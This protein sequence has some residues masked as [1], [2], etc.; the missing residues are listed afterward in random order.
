MAPWLLALVL[1]VSM[2]PAGA[3]TGDQ[4][5]QAANVRYAAP[6]GWTVEDFPDHRGTFMYALRARDDVE[7]SI[8]IELSSTPEHSIQEVFERFVASP[9][10]KGKVQKDF[11]RTMSKTRGGAKYGRVEY[12]QVRNGVHSIESFVVLPLRTG[13]SVFVYISI[14]E[15]D[16][17]KHARTALEFLDSIA[18]PK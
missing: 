6:S 8:G 12:F 1:A 10:A 9:K 17:A 13:L 2:L 11:T 3:Q 5:L 7:A 15:A 14:V 18:V 16:Y 4:L